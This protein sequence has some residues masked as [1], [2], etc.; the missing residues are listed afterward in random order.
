MKAFNGC[1]NNI[2][3]SKLDRF[4]HFQRQALP[5]LR[6]RHDEWWEK[7]DEIETYAATKN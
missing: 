4:K 1:L 7:A 6:T 2:F 3:T 5:A